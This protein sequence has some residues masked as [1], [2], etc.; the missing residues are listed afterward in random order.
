[1]SCST[2]FTDSNI[3]LIF[4]FSLNFGLK[5]WN[6]RHILQGLDG[7]ALWPRKPW[8]HLNKSTVDPLLKFFSPIALLDFSSKH[9]FEEPSI[10]VNNMMES[11][12]SLLCKRITLACMAFLGIFQDQTDQ[13]VDL[14]TKNDL[15]PLKDQTLTVMDLLIIWH[16]DLSQQGPDKREMTS[17]TFS[18]RLW[19]APSRIQLSEWSGTSKNEMHKEFW[20]LTESWLDRL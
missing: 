10:F 2:P 16:K 15:C 7:R 3:T 6:F 1:M 4:T 18:V 20:S 14:M 12:R 17:M 5:W 13:L 19:H 11:C 9:S 8:L